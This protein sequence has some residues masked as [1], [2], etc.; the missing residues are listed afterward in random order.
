MFFH[1][2]SIVVAQRPMFLGENPPFLAQPRLFR[3]QKPIQKRR[4]HGS[5][6]PAL[7]DSIGPEF[8]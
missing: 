4:L 5:V 2:S 1:S 6:G 3:R 7:R 8:M